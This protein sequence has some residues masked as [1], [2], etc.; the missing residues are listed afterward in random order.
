MADGQH[1]LSR[2]IPPA[3]MAGRACPEPVPSAVEGLSRRTLLGAPL[4][5]LILSGAEGSRSALSKDA[6]PIWDRALARLREAR[7]ALD[8]AA[9][10]PDQDRYDALLDSHSDALAA[11]LALPA[12]DLAALARK[13]DLALDERTGEFGGDC[14]AMRILKRDARRLASPR[15]ARPKS[16]SHQ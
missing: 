1:K 5:P 7:A 13:L 9:H 15:L 8:S 10:E 14:A 12:P 2:P 4:V 3:G 6:V 11:L 16:D